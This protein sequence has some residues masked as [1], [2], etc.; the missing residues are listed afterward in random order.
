[1]RESPACVLARRSRMPAPHVK[2]R[3]GQPFALAAL[4]RPLSSFVR[5]RGRR[6]AALRAQF[7]DQCPVVFENR[8]ITATPA[9][10][11]AIPSRAGRSSFCPKTA[12]P[13]QA[14]STMPRPDQ[15]A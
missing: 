8:L 6:P 3:D 7:R 15:I 1:M 10:I 12:Q 14:I 11:K 4:D 5:P 9:M 13:M 2:H